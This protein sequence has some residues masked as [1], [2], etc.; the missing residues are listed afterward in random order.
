MKPLQIVFDL[1]MLTV[2]TENSLKE[3]DLK[4]SIPFVTHGVESLDEDE[5]SVEVTGVDCEA[6][7]GAERTD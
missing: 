1:G 5:R 2:S 7:G 3:K 4:L 6:M